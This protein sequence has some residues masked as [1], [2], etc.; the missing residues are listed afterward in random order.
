VQRSRFLNYMLA[1]YMRERTNTAA[2]L[3]QSSARIWLAKKELRAHFGARQIQSLWRGARSRDNIYR[4]FVA[5]QIQA[6]IRRWLARTA[7]AEKLGAIILLQSLARGFLGR[8]SARERRLIML[9]VRSV[10]SIKAE[11]VSTTKT[12][13]KVAIP[14]KGSQNA[15]IMSIRTNR[16]IAAARTIQRFFLMVKAAVDREI[17][18]THTKKRRKNK[19]Q[20][21]H[22]NRKMIE[23]ADDEVLENIWVSTVDSES[24]KLCHVPRTKCSSNQRRP[25]MKERN[26]DSLIRLINSCARGRVSPSLGRESPASTIGRSSSALRAHQQRVGPIRPVDSFASLG[27]S[28]AHGRAS[29][30]HGRQ[31]S[32]RSSRGGRP[33]SRGVD[34]GSESPGNVFCFRIPPSRFAT[35]SRSEIDQDY[36]LEEAWID[37]E[38]QD[39][40]ERRM[41]ERKQK[42]IY[43]RPSS[44]SDRPNSRSSDRPSSRASQNELPPSK[45]NSSHGSSRSSSRPGSR[46]SVRTMQV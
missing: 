19:L 41:S 44:H 31:S 30:L 35:L 43:H 1:R 12:L 42:T 2:I 7:A 33:P 22:A 39:A 15:S 27:N 11:S 38:I 46:S 16:E 36:S 23:D 25:V 32:R 10:A 8:R 17:R 3:V 14:K 6:I 28:C 37:T 18:R 45:A 9:F 24:L 20:S 21:Y 5:I 26:G 13:R 29:P 4:G 34:V 40:K